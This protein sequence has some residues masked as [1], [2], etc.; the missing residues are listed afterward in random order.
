MQ[1]SPGSLAHYDFVSLYETS[2]KDRRGDVRFFVDQAKKSAGPVLEYGA[3][4]GRV[5]IPMARAGID[6]LAVD[7]SA[8]M[9]AR[10]RQHLADCSQKVQNRV[11]VQKGDMRRL[12]LERRFPLVLATFNVVA[13]LATFKDFGAFLRRAKEH[14][15]PGGQLLFDVPIPHADEVEADPEEL[16]QVPRFKHPDTGQWIRQT[17][18]FEYDPMTQALLVESTLKVEGWPDPV[19]IP[20]V[21]RQWFPKEVEALLYYEGFSNVEMLADY[22]EQPAI[23][24]E[25]TLIFRATL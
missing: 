18:R 3:G 22:S 14:L 16:Y 21:L 2:F 13:H 9:L 7:A 5:T 10:L 8:P 24:A 11:E 23:V 17:E 25:D 20:L 12:S 6:V 1:K 4:A 15:E 19:V